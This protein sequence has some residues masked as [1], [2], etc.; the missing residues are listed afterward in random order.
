VLAA[1]YNLSHLQMRPEAVRFVSLFDDTLDVWSPED[2][3]LVEE[4]SEVSRWS[5]P[6]ELAEKLAA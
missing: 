5:R 3:R 2:F 4:L 1:W 6:D